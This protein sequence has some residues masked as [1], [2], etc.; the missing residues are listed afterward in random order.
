MGSTWPTDLTQSR[1]LM[2]PVTFSVELPLLSPSRPS[3][4]TRSLSSEPRAWSS[5]V[6]STETS[7]RSS[8]T[9]K[10]DILPSL[11][12]VPSTVDLP[13]RCSSTSSEACFPT[14]PLAAR[15]PSILLRY[16]CPIR[17]VQARHCPIRL[18]ADQAEAQP[19]VRFYR[20]TRRRDRLEV[21][22]CRR[23]PRSQATGQG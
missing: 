4:E 21:P 19:K 6:T 18:Q 1:S 3:T 20:P 8:T 12:E 7:S 9:L 11:L 22:D 15:L 10:S 23:D 16:P 5:P 2:A 17:Q 13:P 14:R